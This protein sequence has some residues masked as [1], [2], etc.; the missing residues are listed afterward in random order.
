[1]YLADTLSHAFLPD[2]N[3]CE[4]TQELEAVDHR[5][6]LPVSKERWQ[7]IK[8]ATADDPVLQQLRA[9]IRQ[10]WPKQRSDVPGCL[11]VYFDIGDVL[12][13]QDELVFKGQ[14]LVV[15]ASLRKGRMAVLYSS[16]IG[17]E[18][19]VRKT[20]PSCDSTSQSTPRQPSQRTAATAG[21]GDP[22]LG[23]SRRRPLRSRQQHSISHFRLLQQFHSSCSSQDH[24]VR[25]CHQ[26]NE[27]HIR[28]VWYPS[29]C[30]S[31]TTASSSLPPNFLFSRYNLF[32][33]P[34][35]IEW[36]G[37][38]PCE[39]SEKALQ[40]IRPIRVLSPVLDWRNT[41]TEGFGTSPA[42]RLMGRRC[43]TLVPVAGTLL[44][45]RYS[46][47]TRALIG[48]KQRKQQH[49]NHHVKPLQPIDQGESVRMKLPG[50][51]TRSPDTCFERLARE[52]TK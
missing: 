24:D 43:K 50:Q 15:P 18:G 44:Q 23:Q 37:R 35:S 11:Y 25:Q 42:Q 41:P 7:Q 20:R 28:A 14:L 13:V 52:A 40:R 36:K 33:L 17:I 12:T 26:R 16:H 4:L 22:T 51:K 27:S 9:T 34:S 49:C 31:Q 2:V 47:E 5:A 45:P 32:P 8:Y 29:T 1:M 21:G 3:A 39:N 10:G 38:K 48:S 46:T 6:F 19:C 30:S